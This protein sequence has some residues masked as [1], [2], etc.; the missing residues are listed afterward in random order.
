MTLH[1]AGLSTSDIAPAELLLLQYGD[2]VNF[3]DTEVHHERHERT[4]A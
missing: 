3:F 2:L 4:D 1:A